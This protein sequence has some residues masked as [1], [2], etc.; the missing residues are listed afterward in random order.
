MTH[1]LSF[2]QD[3]PQEDIKYMKQLSKPSVQ[4]LM[5]KM[6]ANG[7]HLSTGTGFVLNSAN[8]PVLVTNRHNVTGANNITNELLHPNGYIPNEV[9][10]LHNRNGRL[11]EWVPK[12]EIL[13]DNWEPMWIE[14]PTLGPH[15]DFVALPLTKLDDV[16]LYPYSLENQPKILVR[17]SD[18]INVVGFPFG[19]TAGGALAIWSTGFMASEPDV[20]YEN[21]PKFLIDCRARQGQS[22]SAVIAHYNSGMISMEDG[23]SAAFAGPVTK[24][25]GI[26]SGRI[27]DQ[28]DL[29]IVW[30]ASAI[31]ELIDSII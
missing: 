20:D 30:K 23:S 27:N 22:G 31:K 1:L 10:I 14:H 15:A 26:Y 29:G 19:L 24:F 13:L 28:S 8:G 5:L 12:T 2:T 7:N 16:Q 4:S 3:Q 6:S 25:M 17:P 18:A 11:G 9:T 21:Q